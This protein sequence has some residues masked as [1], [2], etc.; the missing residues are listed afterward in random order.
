MLGD[1]NAKNNTMPRLASIH[2]A[3][4]NAAMQG[5]R[6]AFAEVYLHYRS[7]VFAIC[8]RIVK[9]PAISEEL[10]QDTFLLVMRKIHMF[11]GDS[12]FSTWLYQIARN[13]CLMYI[14]D[15]QAKDTRE[16]LC[17]LAE[18]DT[19]TAQVEKLLRVKDRM[20]ESTAERVTLDRLIGKMAPGYRSTLLLH[21]FLGYEHEEICEMLSVREGTSKSQLHKGRQRLR[22]MYK[23]A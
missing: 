10:A 7:L 6:D 23:A 22:Q 4:L 5:D 8:Y 13:T 3:V 17:E 20:L 16:S 12:Q 9:N 18:D 2:P 1:S 11:K 15:Q 19:K 14:R 21:D